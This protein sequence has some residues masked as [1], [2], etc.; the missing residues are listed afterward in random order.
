MKRLIALSIF[1]LLAV[2]MLPTSQ[3][4][5]VPTVV[6]AADTCGDYCICTQACAAWA[7]FQGELCLAMGGTL[8]ECANVRAEAGQQCRDTSCVNCGPCS[9]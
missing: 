4:T 1:V 5:S 3:Q 2:S 9:N 7:Q 6:E 8:A